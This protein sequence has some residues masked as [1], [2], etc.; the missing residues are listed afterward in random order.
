MSSSQTSLFVPQTVVTILIPIS[1]PQKQLSDSQ[2]EVNGT[3]ADNHKFI[4]HKNIVCHH[5]PFF[6][7]PFNGQFVEG[8]TQS[9]MLDDIDPV[10]FGSFVHWLYH[11]KVEAAIDIN[12]SPE[13]LVKFWVMAERFLLPT[14]QN[15]IMDR[16]FE[17]LG[18]SG[19]EYSV[20]AAALAIQASNSDILNNMLLNCVF[21]ANSTMGHLLRNSWIDELLVDMLRRGAKGDYI[22]DPLILSNDYH[23]PV[24][25]QVIRR[26]ERR[27]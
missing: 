7:A 3:D 18:A 1:D 9:M 25:V 13:M 10:I 2:P 26:S 14:L 20:E 23:V 16:L 5:S 24:E 4:V 21:G 17:A 11:R 6:S 15:Q 12:L 22:Q 19:S 27:L 8:Q